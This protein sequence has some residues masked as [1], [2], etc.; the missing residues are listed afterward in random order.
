MRKIWLPAALFLFAA[1]GVS[2]QE[3]LPLPGAAAP[4]LELPGV[5]G[6]IYRL[7]AYRGKVVLLNFWA[8]WCEPCREEMPSIERL[9]RSLQGD[10]FVVL[11]VNVGEGA[12]AARRF[13]D[14]VQLSSVLLLDRD[15]TTARAWGARA[16]PSTFI[17]GPDGTIRYRYVGALDW[18]SPAVRE[19]ITGLM[20]RRPSLRSASALP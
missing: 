16:L 13:A 6:R 19:A 17:V 4:A 8:S 1:L 11:A 9:R 18:S 2:A 7:E 12:R 20:P 14:A 10:P 15:G 5:D 3:L